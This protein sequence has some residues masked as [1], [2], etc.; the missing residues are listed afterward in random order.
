MCTAMASAATL[1]HIVAP[2]KLSTFKNWTVG[3]D[4]ALACQAVALLPDDAPD[5]S[6]SIVLTREAGVSGT[7][8]IELSNFVS[9]SGGY[10]LIIDGRVASAGAIVT[11]S[12]SIEITGAPAVRVA[13]AFAKGK[14]LRLL[15]S[16]GAELGTA[17]LSGATAALRFIDSAQ[18]R[19]GSKGAIIATSRK[20]A[21]ARVKALPVI[22]AKKIVPSGVLPDASALVALSEGSPCA[23][24]RFGSTEDTAFSLGDA[25]NPQAL[26]LLNCG[27]GAYNQSTGVYVGKRDA[28][29]RWSFAPAEF[30]Y[31]TTGFSDGSKLPILINS[32]WNAAT[33]TIS[34]YA[35][36]RGVGDCGSSES[37]VWDGAIFRL[38][39]AT[40][41]DECR[42]SVDWIPV[43]RAEV[44]L[45]G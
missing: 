16:A 28:K 40:R 30:D 39:N 6:L 43:W 33:Q 12:G 36:G 41:M 17:S 13:R 19:A 2:A 31:A 26:V 1:P 29:G 34:S 7:L 25:E 20:K 14:S 23:A 45:T 3:C 9:K 8:K 21:T 32:D 11:D 42:G 24:E 37:Y 5:R 38:T 22:T 18:G 10:R 44:R 15:D 35:K 4:N 27:A